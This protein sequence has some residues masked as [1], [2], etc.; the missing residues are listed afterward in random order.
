MPKSKAR[1]SNVA[2]RPRAPKTRT[3]SK[4]KPKETIGVGRSIGSHVGDLIEQG[5]RSLF[6]T[7]TGIGDYHV[8]S[9]TLL[10][11]A[12]P[13]VLRN[14]GRTNIIRH[15]EY[16]QDVVGSSSFSLSSFPINP[17]SLQ[18]FPWLQAIAQ[19]YEQYVFHGLIF[20]FKSTS[21]DALNSTNTALGTVIMSTEYNA[22][23]YSFANKQEME[24]HEFSTSCKPSCDMLHPIECST[25]QTPTRVFYTRPV[26]NANVADL[27]F[28]DMGNFQLATVGMQAV[29]TIGELWCTYEVELLKPALNPV[30]TPNTSAAVWNFINMTT[31]AIF[32][33][34]IP[35]T[36]YGAASAYNPFVS[37]G[38]VSATLTNIALF[39]IGSVWTFAYLMNGTAVQGTVVPWT[40][41]GATQT[42]ILDNG[43]GNP[44]TRT[45]ISSG[46]VDEYVNLMGSFTITGTP[47]VLNS[48]SGD[49]PGS[50]SGSFCLFRLS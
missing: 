31:T 48:T 4:P 9:N 37:F 2:R 28:V 49:F 39:P 34:A 7:I 45:N 21:A 44:S 11:G 36:L 41:T 29:A 1:K 13:P 40:F 50:S 17:G 47:V 6:K 38:T 14:S 3:R 5:A 8:E 18:T 26:E 24:N 33:S 22:N 43:A 25:S 15:R 20:E 23:N 10:S 42:S 27:R 35:T 16:I 12:S 30:I 32:G 19:N 46:S